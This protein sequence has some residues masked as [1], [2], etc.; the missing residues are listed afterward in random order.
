MLGSSAPDVGANVKV[1][2]AVNVAGNALASDT[3]TDCC[4]AGAAVAGSTMV[5]AGAVGRATLKLSLP[6]ASA[7]LLSTAYTVNGKVPAADGVPDRVPFNARLNP[8]GRVAD[9]HWY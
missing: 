4:V 1:R 8:G 9:C 6:L 3:C 2:L 7:P 5:A